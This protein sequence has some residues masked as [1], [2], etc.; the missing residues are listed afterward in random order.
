MKSRDTIHIERIKKELCYIKKTFMGVN[1]ETYLQSDDLQHI[2]SMS[3]III[4]ECAN[5]LS[6]EFR[7]ANSQIPWTDI[8]AVRNIAA[9]GYWELDTEIIWEAINTS[10]PELL[11]FFA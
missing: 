4:G 9:H 3:F 1:K 7:E 11:D 10:V 2:V 6:E 5:R 8:I